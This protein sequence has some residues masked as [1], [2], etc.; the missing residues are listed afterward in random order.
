MAYVD[1]AAAPDRTRAA[2]SAEKSHAPVAVAEVVGGAVVVVAGGGLTVWVTVRV[3]GSVTVTVV[4]V[5]PEP[6]H[7]ARARADASGPRS[8]DAVRVGFTHP[9]LPGRPEGLAASDRRPAA[10]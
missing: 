6:V 9:T 3:T 4:V 2:R 5:V 7:P 1:P 8:R 10:S